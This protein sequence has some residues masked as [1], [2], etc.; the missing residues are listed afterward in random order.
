MAHDLYT[1]VLKRGQ[2]EERGQLIVGRLAGAGSA[3]VG[4]LCV[5]LV[6]VFLGPDVLGKDD[7]IWPLAIPA[8]VSVP[9]GFLCAY[10]GTRIG[11][12]RVGST[13]MPYDEFERRAFPSPAA[14]KQRPIRE[15]EPAGVA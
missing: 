10:V 13:G 5:A 4:G 2:V 15:A 9:A 14:V 8:I 3:M 1:S 12:G 11:R 6:L 7:A